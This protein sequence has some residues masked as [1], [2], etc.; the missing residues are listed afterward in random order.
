M[1]LVYV[2]AWIVAPINSEQFPIKKNNCTLVY[3]DPFSDRI[4]TASYGFAAPQLHS[5]CTSPVD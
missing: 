5:N 4:S 2:M 1:S 3:F